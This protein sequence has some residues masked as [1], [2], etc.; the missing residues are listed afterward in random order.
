MGWGSPD[1]YYQPEAFG[2]TKVA[3]VN[4]YYESYEFDLTVVWKDKEGNFYWAR[5][6]GC[7]CPSPFEEYTSLDKLEKGSNF[8]A[9]AALQ[10]E[11]AGISESRYTDTS[12][13]PIEVADAITSIMLA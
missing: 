12:H 5:D 2:L 1:V 7:S 9:A 3:E 13:V 8:Q 4:W 6:S 11:M 10:T